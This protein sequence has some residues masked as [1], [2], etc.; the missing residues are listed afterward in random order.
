MLIILLSL[1][2][3]QAQKSWIERAFYKRECV[4]IIPSTKDPH[5]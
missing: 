2:L 5:R 1:S 3:F 4:H